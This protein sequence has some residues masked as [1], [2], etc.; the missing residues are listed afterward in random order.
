M[1]IPKAIEDRILK[2][3]PDSTGEITLLPPRHN[4][5]DEYRPVP[6]SEEN[7]AEVEVE[8]IQLELVFDGVWAGMSKTT[9]KLFVSFEQDDLT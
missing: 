6:F 1:N 9:R 7:Y 8:H 4:Q 5:V 2:K 3:F